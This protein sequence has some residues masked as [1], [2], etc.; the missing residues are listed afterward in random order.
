MFGLRGVR[1]EIFG[2]E[3]APNGA[4][5]EEPWGILTGWILC[6]VRVNWLGTWHLL[7]G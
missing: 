4:V 5:F 7:T 1:R 6:V 2:A 3:D